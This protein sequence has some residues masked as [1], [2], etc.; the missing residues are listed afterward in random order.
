[1]LQTLVEVSKL[2]RRLAV[3]APDGAAGLVEVLLVVGEREE[4]LE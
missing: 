4:V 3:V 2:Y 1:M